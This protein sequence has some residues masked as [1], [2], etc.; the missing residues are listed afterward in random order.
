LA[1]DHRQLSGS[2]RCGFFKTLMFFENWAECAT[3]AAPLFFC[4][5]AWEAELPELLLFLLSMNMF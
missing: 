2:T 3:R 1:Q 5:L 4:G